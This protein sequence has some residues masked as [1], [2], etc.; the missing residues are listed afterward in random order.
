MKTTSLCSQS[1]GFPHGFNPQNQFPCLF[2]LLPT[3]YTLPESLA[4]LFQSTSGLGSLG[5]DLSLHVPLLWSAVCRGGLL[6]LLRLQPYLSVSRLPSAISWPAPNISSLSIS[7][8]A[9]QVR[10]TSRSRIPGLARRHAIV[11]PP[12]SRPSLCSNRKLCHAAGQREPSH[13]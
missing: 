1:S 7:F 13:R 3:T 2:S 4:S 9:A 12:E 11:R 10:S 6:S 5:L 8:L